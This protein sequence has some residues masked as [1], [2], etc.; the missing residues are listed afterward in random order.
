MIAG[1]L[2]VPVVSMFTK[3][4]DSTLVEEAFS[5]YDK[6]VLGPQRSALG[7]HGE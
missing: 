7:E 5:C 1:L 2:I 6:K 3:K 4:P